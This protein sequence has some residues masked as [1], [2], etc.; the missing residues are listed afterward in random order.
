ME[1]IKKVSAVVVFHDNT[2][3]LLVRNTVVDGYG[4]WKYDLPKGEIDNGLTP[5]Q[6]A[7]KEFKEECGIDLD[8]NVLVY[9]GK[10]LYSK[11]KDLEF[12]IY[13]VDSVEMFT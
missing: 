11:Y 1:I 2:N 13:E 12:F 7:L 8:P 10:S 5:K 9:Y 4:D 3:L 6:T